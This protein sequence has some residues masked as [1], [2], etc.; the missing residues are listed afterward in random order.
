MKT[1]TKPYHIPTI[2]WK[3]YIILES[4]VLYKFW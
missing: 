3:Q 2:N 1:N 4:L